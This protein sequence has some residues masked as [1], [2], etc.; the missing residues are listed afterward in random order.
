MLRPSQG[1]GYP[2]HVD[3]IGEQN[4]LPPQTAASLWADT[5]CGK[6]VYSHALYKANI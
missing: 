3:T 4:R 6:H 5:T 1:W 2:G